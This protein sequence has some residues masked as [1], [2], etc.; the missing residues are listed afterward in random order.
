MDVPFGEP[1]NPTKM[2][3]SKLQ[4]ALDMTLLITWW[5]LRPSWSGKWWGTGNQGLPD[6]QMKNENSIVQKL[7]LI[8]ACS[9][10]QKMPK[11]AFPHCLNMF[12]MDY[13]EHHWTMVIKTL[14]EVPNSPQLSPVDLAAGPLSL[15]VCCRGNGNAFEHLPIPF[16]LTHCAAW[17]H[18][19]AYLLGPL[20]NA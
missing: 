7:C 20:A 10:S 19:W 2:T 13:T 9:L 6:F 15:A 5:C 1:P 3:R 16:S 11:W 12:H 8:R 14:W 4:K 18:H 17:D